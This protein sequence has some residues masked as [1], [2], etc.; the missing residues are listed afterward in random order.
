MVFPAV[1]YTDP[2]ALAGGTPAIRCVA[3][4]K[5]ALGF[6]FFVLVGSGGVS[7]GFGV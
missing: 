4:N 5:A 6:G 3:A 2:N 7:V 1:R